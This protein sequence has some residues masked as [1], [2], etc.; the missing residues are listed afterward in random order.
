MGEI[1]KNDLCLT[2]KEIYIYKLINFINEY[3]GISSFNQLERM[4]TISS[5]YS[6]FKLL[7]TNC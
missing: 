7:L 5:H 1:K 4:I 2:F 6:F 3:L